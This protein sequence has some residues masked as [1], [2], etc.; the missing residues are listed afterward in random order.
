[1]TIRTIPELGPYSCDCGAVVWGARAPDGYVQR[2]L[3]L[4]EHDGGA[5]IMSDDEK[6]QAARVGLNPGD[7]KIHHHNGDGPA[8][9][10]VV[11]LARNQ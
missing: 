3:V 9:G 11:D 4:E 10:D 6:Y 7:L 8:L 1:M 2:R 5:W